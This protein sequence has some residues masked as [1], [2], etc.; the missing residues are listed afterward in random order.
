MTG[1]AKAKAM[2]PVWLMGLGWAPLGI[3]GAVALLIVPQLLAARHVS[4]PQIAQITALALVPGFCAFLVAPILDVRFSRRA[5]AALFAVLGGIF[6]FLALIEI[7]DL[8]LVGP[9]LFGALFSIQLSASAAGGWLGSL[10]PKES[11]NALGAWFIVANIGGFGLTSIIGVTLLRGLPYT[12]G[13]AILGALV[14]A[15]ALAFPFIPAPGPDRRLAKES[16]GQFTADLFALARKPTVL[17]SLLL[18]GVPAASFAL[19]N[20]L[21]GL[22]RD[23]GASEQFVAFV[24]GAGV[25]VAG[26]FGSLMVPVVAARLAPRP[27]YLMI[28]AVG[29][30]FTLALIPAPRTPA[31]FTLA[32]VGENIFQSASFAT[33]NIVMFRAIGKDNP[34][35]A[36]QF[37]LMA[38][39]QGLPLS[40]MQVL[41]GRA[42]GAG[43]LAGSYLMDGGLGVAACAL[44]AL[45][46][47]VAAKRG[48]AQPTAAAAAVSS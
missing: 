28:G 16:F 14:A 29:A 43:G 3:S 22:G 30:A 7:G 44:L 38:A 32:M 46:L 10:V 33:A 39:A 5:Y 2:P 27:L 18:F 36:T 9:L 35:A 23:F 15:P 47:V 26:V 31:T 17:L 48:R 20:I 42:Y 34:F 25:T 13:A 1:A 37:A 19:T 12:L 40:Y 4:E 6:N 45:V 24:G 21:G 41:D 8:S 11:D